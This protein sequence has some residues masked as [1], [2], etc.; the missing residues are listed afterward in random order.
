MALN[1]NQ[2]QL[3][4]D[5]GVNVEELNDVSKVGGIE[6]AAPETFENGA[7]YILV[8]NSTTNKL[9]LTNV[10]SSQAETGEG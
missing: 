9:T 2:A 6:I 7:A 8:Y 4:D 5:T 3:Y 1:K 10:D